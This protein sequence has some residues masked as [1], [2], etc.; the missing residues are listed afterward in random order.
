VELLP[1]SEQTARM[2][3][4]IARHPDIS[5]RYHGSD[6]PPSWRTLYVLSQLPPGE[7]PRRIEAH[8]ITPELERATAQQWASTYQAAKQE[9]LTAWN[10]AYDA[11]TAALSYAKT[12]PPPADTDIYA[13]VDDFTARVA[14]LAAITQT[15]SNDVG[16]E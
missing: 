12:Y 7:I 9:A 6:L 15:W 13:S 10:Q 16:S 8:E 14:E 1:F 11:I 3:M 4:Q 2:L 5:N